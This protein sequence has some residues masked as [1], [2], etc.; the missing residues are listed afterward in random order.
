M[1]EVI[2][3]PF[4]NPN[5]YE[6]GDYLRLDTQ[7]ACLK[8]MA[9]S[10]TAIAAIEGGIFAPETDPRERADRSSA[11]STPTGVR[12]V[13]APDVDGHHAVTYTHIREHRESGVVDEL[14]EVIVKQLP[15]RPDYE[16]LTG[17][18][19]VA[20]RLSYERRRA[21]L[22]TYRWKSENGLVIEMVTADGQGRPLLVTDPIDL[23]VNSANTL[24][25]AARDTALVRGRTD[26]VMELMPAD[27]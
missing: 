11:F 21:A 24:R 5:V 19:A 15:P 4:D 3:N 25:A 20:A 1:P 23:L 26:V 27:D 13:T 2:F 16:G 8:H 18:Q 12:F 9:I 10:M 6:G 22:P 7:E 14:D 17:S